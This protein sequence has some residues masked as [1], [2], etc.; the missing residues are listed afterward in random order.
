MER[1]SNITFR[2]ITTIAL[3]ASNVTCTRFEKRKTIS[4]PD[5]TANTNLTVLPPTPT[6]LG[7]EKGFQLAP[8]TTPEA[9]IVRKIAQGEP[10]IEVEFD[11]TKYLANSQEEA[12]KVAQSLGIEHPSN[13]CWVLTAQMLK[14]AG[15]LSDTSITDFWLL[16][17]NKYPEEVDKLLPPSEFE[18]IYFGVPTQ[19]IDFSA[20]PLEVW[21]IVY[22]SAGIYGK[23]GHALMVTRIDEIGRA[24]TT[25]NV[26]QPD[27]TFKIQD[28]LLYDP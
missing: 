4:T 8:L 22:L 16:D 5:A 13:M 2:V 10:D 26:M 20:N 28:I 15:L 12:V 14:D 1:Q 3:L 7:I 6:T 18:H 21:D 23:F 9:P 25:T 11:T 19:R 17:P 24:Y 27:G